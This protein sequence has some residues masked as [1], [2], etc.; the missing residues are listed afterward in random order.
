MS[1][2]TQ[3]DITALYGAD[4]LAAADQDGDGVIDAAQ[5]ASALGSAA[6]EIDSYIGVRYALPISGTHPHL[7]QICVD[8]ALYR[9]SNARGW[10]TDELR[11]R[12]EDAVKALRAYAEG[13][14]ALNLP[15]DPD[16]ATDEDGGSS[17]RPMLTSGP[18]RI[19]S[20]DKLRG[21]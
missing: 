9:L 1:Y 21:L 3:S 14:A 15:A 17:P 10:V 16:I 12:Y 4:A 2:A 18:A 20:R 7:M 6:A 11:L 5:V 13:K 8:V 19:F